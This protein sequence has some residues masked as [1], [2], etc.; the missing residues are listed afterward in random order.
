MNSLWME[1]YENRKHPVLN[2]NI[3]TD[4]AIIGGGLAGLLCSYFL[5]KRGVNNAVLEAKKIGMG[6]THC[7]TA[8]ITAQ[9]G[10][11]YSKIEEKSGFNAAKEYFNSN[12]QAVEAY[13][14]LSQSIECDFEE[15]TAYV[16][17]KNDRKKLEKEAD[18]YRRMG[19]SSFIDEN[20]YIPVKTVGA[21]GMRY[22][23]QFHPLK[24]IDSISAPLNIYENTFVKEIQPGKVIT[25]NGIVSAR[26]IIIATHYPIMNLHGLYFMKLY[27]HRSYVLAL[28]GALNP[29]GI[30][31]DEAKGGLS[32]R[33]HGAHLLLGG[34][35]HQT[36]KKGGAWKELREIASSFYPEAIESY[37]WAT[38]DCMTLDSMPYIGL[39]NKNNRELY[40]A[41]GFNKWGMTGSMTAASVLADMITEGGSRYEKLFNPSRS[42]LSPQLFINI[43]QSALGLLSFGKR[44][45][46]MGCAL[47]WNPHERT[48]DC[49]CHG[50]R[51]SQNGNLIN[52]PAQRGIEVKRRKK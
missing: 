39:H 24:F 11:I 35:S 45:S 37:F 23:A 41:T 18:I 29:D 38:Q 21:L 1:E 26:R 42:M 4:T 47:R 34:G 43:G 14:A 13:R 40:V 31:I 20:P 25:E 51:F 17:S 7:T 22:Q 12:Q 2:G 32:F 16:Y 50:S 46:H 44:C 33:T 10:I 3:E 28:K 52:N 30:Y 5:T 36:G 49:P 9:H 48:W 19:L 15:K 6:V 8:K 27:Q